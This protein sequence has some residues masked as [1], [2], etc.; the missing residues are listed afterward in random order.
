MMAGANYGFRYE[1]T[2]LAKG[3]NRR[4]LVMMGAMTGAGV[5]AAGSGI[6][7]AWAEPKAP[8]S[9]G[10]SVKR[11]SQDRCTHHRHHRY[12]TEYR[13]VSGAQICQALNYNLVIADPLKG[14]PEECA[15]P[16]CYK[17][18]RRPRY[19]AGR[20]RTMKVGRVS[21]QTVVDVC[22]GQEFGGYDSALHSHRV[23]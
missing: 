1:R 9:D 16:W 20:H 3:I 14:L 22:N 10:P 13:S 19:R 6:Q 5:M 2:G 4:A 17:C 8:P 7:A 18:R 23:A 21:L 12:P 15:R 11:G